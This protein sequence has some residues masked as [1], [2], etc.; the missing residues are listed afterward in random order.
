VLSVLQRLKSIELTLEG[1]RIPINFSVGWKEYE[2][3]DSL[4]DLMIEADKALYLNKQGTKELPALQT[5]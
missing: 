2:Q 5:S 3:D 4:Q 1:Q